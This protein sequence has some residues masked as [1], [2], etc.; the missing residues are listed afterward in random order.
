[1]FK[2]VVLLAT[3]NAAWSTASQEGPS[4][5]ELG[6]MIYEKCNQGANDGKIS[7]KEA[8][9]CGAPEEFKG[10]FLEAAGEDGAVDEGEFMHECK[11][12]MKKHRG[13]KKGGK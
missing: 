12:Q 5:K 6:E 13:G 1:M 10:D 11:E 2:F 3:V 8:S 7:W 4:C 9:D